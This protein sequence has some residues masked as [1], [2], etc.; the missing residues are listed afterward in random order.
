VDNNVTLVLKNITL[1]SR[2]EANNDVA[3]IRVDTGGILEAGSGVL[4]TA[5]S[6]SVYGGG[7]YVNN[8]SFTK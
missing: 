8:G 3:L 4:I 2:A 7:V 6:A 5:N 1:R